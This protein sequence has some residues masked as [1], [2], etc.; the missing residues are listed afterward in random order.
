MQLPTTEVKFID[1]YVAL[2]WHFKKSIHRNG[3]LE[4][5]IRLLVEVGSGSWQQREEGLVL[6][7]DCNLPQTQAAAHLHSNC[8]LVCVWEWKRDKSE[9]KEIR[10]V[11]L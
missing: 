11:L 9:E 8:I 6:L 2:I 5:K 4:A 10:E 3:V 7:M 1:K